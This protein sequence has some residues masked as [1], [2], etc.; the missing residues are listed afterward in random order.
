MAEAI[1]SVVAD[2]S[3]IG[4]GLACALGEADI[5][6]MARVRPLRH[7]PS[8][9]VPACPA[10]VDRVAVDGGSPRHRPCAH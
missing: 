7:Q 1:S 5:A 3:V 2:C 8:R 10:D 6:V 4:S 9:P